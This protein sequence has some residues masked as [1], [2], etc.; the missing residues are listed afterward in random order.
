MKQGNLILVFTIAIC[1]L[2]LLT[3]C[4]NSGKGMK[5]EEPEQVITELMKR[6]NEGGDYLVLCVGSINKG[7]LEKSLKSFFDC[8]GGY[9]F[10][11]SGSSIY[12]KI[13]G[14]D[15]SLSEN[16]V[17]IGVHATPKDGDIFSINGDGYAVLD[18]NKKDG[19]YTIVDFK[20]K[21]Y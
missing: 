4:G 14:R 11:E 8:G 7:D 20:L 9:I 21:K 17:S 3:D 13:N 16:Q 19:I 15:L 1:S 5:A 6:Y 10:T 12:E 2:L 18:H